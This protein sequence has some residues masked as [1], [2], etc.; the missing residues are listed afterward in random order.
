MRLIIAG[1]RDYEF[2]EANFERLDAL[3]AVH[4]VTKVLSG[5]ASGADHYGE[6]WARSNG[7]PVEEHP[8]QWD[9]LG[10]RAGP[11]R[12][13]EMA[14][15]ADAVVLFPGGDGTQNMHDEAKAR[16]LRIF[17]WRGD[18]WQGPRGP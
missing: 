10:R 1:G 14:H 12:N 9:A 16:D 11:V 4:P 8:A 18:S 6:V 3:H 13:I 17:D 7:I 2:T 15:Q 5:C